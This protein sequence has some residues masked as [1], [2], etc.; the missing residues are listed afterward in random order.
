MKAAEFKRKIEKLAR[1]NKLSC[2]WDAAHGK[3]SHGTLHLGDKSTTLKDL[4]K[5]I[6]PGLLKSMCDDLGVNHVNWTTKTENPK[7]DN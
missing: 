7:K 6:G 5:E 4:N 3:G 2:S 1:K